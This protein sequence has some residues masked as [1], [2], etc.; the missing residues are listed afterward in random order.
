M[1]TSQ[2]K[3]KARMLQ[4][5]VRDEFR[6]I[7]SSVLDDDDIK[8]QTMGCSGC[9]IVLTPVAKKLI[10]FDIECKNQQS[11]NITSAIK[12][13]EKNSISGRIPIVVFKKNFTHPYVSLSFEN[14]IKLLYK[15]DF[16]IE[17]S[18]K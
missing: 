7:F 9:D 18:Q 15:D 13:A 14:F 12:Q 1:K 17:T 16:T 6:K 5:Y 2:K 3:A 4:N 10:P 11:F 8:A